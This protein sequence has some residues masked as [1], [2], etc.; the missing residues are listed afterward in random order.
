MFTRRQ[1]VIVRDTRTE[2]VDRNITIN[3]ASTDE[4]V[5]LL[6]EMEE[7]AKA[8]VIKA[9]HVGDNSFECVVQVFHEDYNDTVSWRAVFNLNGK[10]LTAT[11]AAPTHKAQ[12]VG[13]MGCGLRDEVAKVIA[14]EVLE[15]GLKG[16]KL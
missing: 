11:F 13:E 9:M 7:K 6:R 12:D 2:Y 5:A 14:S 3:R 15:N 1:P 10:K 4:S 8:Q 16:L